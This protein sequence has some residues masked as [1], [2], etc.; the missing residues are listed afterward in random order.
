MKARLGGQFA[1]LGFGDRDLES[2]D[3]S[4]NI[5]PF[6][7][8]AGPGSIRLSLGLSFLGRLAKPA[9]ERLLTIATSWLVGSPSTSKMRRTSPSSSVR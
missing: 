7:V 1:G 6:G 8:L 2:S 3:E 9:I 5:V 4:S